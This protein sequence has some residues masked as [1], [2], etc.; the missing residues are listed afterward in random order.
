MPNVTADS[1]GSFD[2]GQLVKSHSSADTARNSST[3]TYASSANPNG[4]MHGA[5]F[6]T[7]LIYRTIVSFDLSGN[8]DNGDSLSGNTVD[9]ADLVMTTNANAPGFASF[10]ANTNNLVYVC[11]STENTAIDGDTY[12]ALD[13]YVSSGSY[14][15]E[16]TVYATANEAANTSMTFNLSSDCISDINTQIAAGGRVTMMLLCQDDFLYNT[17]PGGL[18]APTGGTGVFKFEGV[19]FDSAEDS[20]AS[21]RPRLELTYG[22]AA[23]TDNATFFGTNF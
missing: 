19:R 1:D 2:D 17:L 12:S 23:A 10:T 3:G 8:D 14:D 7:K 4:C 16:V 20:T 6:T 21:N 22:A 11:K 18:G 13:G 5:V 15:G 9:S